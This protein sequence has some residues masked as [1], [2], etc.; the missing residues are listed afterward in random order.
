[1]KLGTYKY[2]LSGVSNPK[3]VTT[4]FHGA[5]R[6]KKTNVRTVKTHRVMNYISARTVFVRTFL[7]SKTTVVNKTVEYNIN[8]FVEVVLI[9]NR[10]LQLNVSI[11]FT[12]SYRFVS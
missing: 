4:Q 9:P 2:V 11:Q 7:K 6:K 3:T 5:K 1:M 10:F 12:D 8:A